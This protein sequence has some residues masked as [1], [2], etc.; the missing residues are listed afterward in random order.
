MAADEYKLTPMGR[1]VG[2]IPGSGLDTFG[3]QGLG[4]I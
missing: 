3:V 4:F 1:I 2:G